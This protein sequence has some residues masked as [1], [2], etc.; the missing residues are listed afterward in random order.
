MKKKIEY[1]N[2]FDDADLDKAKVVKDFL[3]RRKDLVLRKGRPI[4][5]R[6]IILD[7]LSCLG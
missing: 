2:N 4:G 1:T 5:Q 6:G 7:S 3:P